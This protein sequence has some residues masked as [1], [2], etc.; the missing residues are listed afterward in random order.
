LY[1]FLLVSVQLLLLGVQSSFSLLDCRLPCGQLLLT[2][3]CGCWILHLFK[4][5]W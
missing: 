1:Q 4:T 2:A 3:C 5:D